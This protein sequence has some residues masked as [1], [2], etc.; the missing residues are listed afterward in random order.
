[1]R[2]SER[3]LP[4]ALYSR[5]DLM[6]EFEIQDATIKTG[7]FQPNGTNSIWLFVTESKP[8]DCTPYVDRLSGDELH[9]EGQSAGRTDRSIIEHALNG[10]E[11]LVFYRRTKTEHADYAFRYEGP[12]QY[13]SHT[14]GDPGSKVPSRFVLRRCQPSR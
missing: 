4:G 9:W 13:V 6:R 5:N 8:S 12:F 2:T 7:V 1:M 14:P 11:L 3:L 10:V